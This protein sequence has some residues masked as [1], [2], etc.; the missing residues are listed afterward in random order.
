MASIESVL[1]L[2]SLPTGMCMELRSRPR[3]ADQQ[4]G[5]Q[6]SSYANPPFQGGDWHL[7]QRKK[8]RST[9]IPLFSAQ[10][11]QA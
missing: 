5:L 6:V 9:H 8:G 7:K 1:P 11:S 10:E 3:E 2:D 4:G